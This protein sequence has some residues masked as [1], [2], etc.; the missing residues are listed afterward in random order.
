MLAAVRADPD[1]FGD[2]RVWNDYGDEDWF[3]AG[4]AAFVS[5]LGEGGADV[6]AHVWPGGH[7]ST[8]WDTHWPQYL[9]FYADALVAC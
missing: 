9:R 7:D 5:A 6:T 1:A 3:V 2:T 4:N 8:Y